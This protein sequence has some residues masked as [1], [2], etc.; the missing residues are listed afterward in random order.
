MGKHSPVIGMFLLQSVLISGTAMHCSS[1]DQSRQ[2]ISI[3]MVFLDFHL[4]KIS[5]VCL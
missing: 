4:M 3:S 5:S 1:G 2:S